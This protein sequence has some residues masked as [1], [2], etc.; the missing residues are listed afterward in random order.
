MLNITSDGPPAD[1][2]IGMAEVQR[3]TSLSTS[4]IYR[5]IAAG[6]FPSAVRIGAR[7]VAWRS[8]LVFEWIAAPNA[9][10][11]GPPA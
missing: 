3:L 1:P 7:R 9:Y 5:H 11:A 10:S 2:L 8:S 6:R 4:T